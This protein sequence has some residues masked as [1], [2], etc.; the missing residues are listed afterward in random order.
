VVTVLATGP[1]GRRFKPGRGDGFLRVI[2]IRITPSF[3]WEIKP[4]VP[5]CKILL[6]VKDSLTISDTYTQNYHLFLSSYPL[7]D[8]SAS[9]IARELWLTS[10]DFSPA[11]IITI[12]WL[13]TLISPR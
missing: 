3:G 10:Q 12:T 8:V 11:G 9:R 1:K 13:Y 7:P 5:W 2:E 4:E 6:H